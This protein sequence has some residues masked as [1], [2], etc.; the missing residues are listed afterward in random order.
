VASV[1]GFGDGSAGDEVGAV[2]GEDDAGGWSSDLMAGAAD[3]LEAA[4]YAGWSFDLD[5]EVDGSHVDA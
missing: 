1:H 2:L 5:D 4:G 3:A